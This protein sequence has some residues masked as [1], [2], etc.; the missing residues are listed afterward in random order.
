MCLGF[1]GLV[2]EGLATEDLAL[3]GLDLGWVGWGSLGGGYRAGVAPASL[4][5]SL[6]LLVTFYQVGTGSS[7]SLGLW[8]GLALVM[9]AL[10]S[11]TPHAVYLCLIPPPVLCGVVIQIGVAQGCKRC[12]PLLPPFA[13]TEGTQPADDAGNEG[14]AVWAAAYHL[15]AAAQ[16]LQPMAT[17]RDN[18]EDAA[19]VTAVQ[20]QLE[21]LAALVAQ[22][23]QEELFHTADPEAAPQ[24][25]DWDSLAASLGYG[26][27][28][29][30]YDLDLAEAYA[31]GDDDTWAALE[32]RGIQASEEAVAA[33]PAA[34]SG[35]NDRATHSVFDAPVDRS[36]CNEIEMEEVGDT[37]GADGFTVFTD[38][39]S[40][41]GDDGSPYSLGWYDYEEGVAVPFIQ[42]HECDD[43]HHDHGCDDHHHHDHGCDDHHHDHS[44]DHHHHR[45]CD[46]H[47]HDHG[48]HHHDHGCEDHHYH[49]HGCDDHHHN[50]HGLDTHQVVS[51]FAGRG[52]ETETN[53]GIINSLADQ[54]MS[55]L[56]IAFDRNTPQTSDTSHPATM[57]RSLL[58]E[59]AGDVT[60]SAPGDVDVRSD[61]GR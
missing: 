51:L 46:D 45:G 22:R 21:Q 54:L 20:Q 59:R 24:D 58:Q 23:S 4:N 47:H 26:Y 60:V 12:A 10:S 9:A 35:N 50:G 41:D 5:P 17:D 16:K 8:E 19:A 40:E 53:N 14:A 29:F 56:H 44:C 33:T 28:E 25:G 38:L 11:F 52:S 39:N 7:S 37:Y 2:L 27:P 6:A 48:C 61:G 55:W 30:D 43:R 36:A 34:F 31:E 1:G 49:D 18:A 13:G 15:L 42:H 32:A 3:V 57:S